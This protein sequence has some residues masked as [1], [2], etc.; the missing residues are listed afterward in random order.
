M[1]ENISFR[2]AE[3]DDL[4]DIVRL[5]LDDNLGKNREIGNDVEPYLK[6]FQMIDQDSMQMLV[7]MCKDESIIGTC[8]LTLMPSMTF[9]GALRL[10]IEAVRVD[11]TLRNDGYGQKMIQWSVEFGKARGAS[12]VQLSTNKKRKSAKNFY[13]KLGFVAS[14]E[15]LKLY[16]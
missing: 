10:N 16:L 8:H 15:G 13:E 14:H 3:I 12:I 1:S 11:S 5:L 4:Q 9:K 2:K 7:V 6:A